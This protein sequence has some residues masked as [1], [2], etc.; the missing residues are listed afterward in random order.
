M[1]EEAVLLWFTFS[2]LEVCP[3]YSSQWGDSLVS[4]ILAFHWFVGGPRDGPKWGS[5]MMVAPWGRSI[6][7]LLQG[8]ERYRDWKCKIEREAG[9]SVGK[10]SWQ[11]GCHDWKHMRNPENENTRAAET[12]QRERLNNREEGVRWD[13]KRRRRLAE[14]RKWDTEEPGGQVTEFELIYW[15]KR[16]GQIFEEGVR[17]AETQGRNVILAPV[18][19]MTQ[20]GN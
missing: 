5:E 20:R 3:S 1:N 14:A 9:I 19:A 7:R 2:C 11:K 4:L 17:C 15:R 16:V 8:S 13:K 12:R 10:R 18:P 6:R